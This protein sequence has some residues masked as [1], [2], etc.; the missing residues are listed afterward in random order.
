MPILP[1]AIYT[2]NAIP[3]KI[4][5]AFFTELEQ[6]ILKFVWNHERHQI[7][8]VILKKKAKAGGIS[9]RL[10]AVIQSCKHQDSMLL[11]QK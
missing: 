10:Q 8:T 7:A 5:L 3:I 11:A 4:T 6:V 9:F 2:F 1:K